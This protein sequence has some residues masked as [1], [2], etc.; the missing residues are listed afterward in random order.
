VCAAYGGLNYITFMQNGEFSVRP[1]TLQKGRLE[2]LN[3]HLMLFYTGIKR[4]A[5]SI[6]ETYVSGING[7]R[8][9]LRIMKDLVEESVEI[10]HSGGSITAF[11]ELLDEAWRAKSTL[12][13]S[14]TN[15]EIDRIYKTAV[16]NGAIGGK[17]MGAGGGGFM[18]FFVP[19]VKQAAVKEALSHLLYVPFR[20][21]FSGSQIIFFD[22]EQEY[23]AE[24][25]HR[26]NHT[27]RA[28]R[29]L[30]GRKPEW[31]S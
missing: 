10:L 16:R 24:E 1:I 12:S 31:T 9:Q 13:T 2:E 22:P 8:R 3:N 15:S 11:G 6:A 27:V 4:T 29:E 21:E 7:R 26:D 28:F 23:Q 25:E 5:S 18:V 14:V 30:S 17:L 19:P 20:F